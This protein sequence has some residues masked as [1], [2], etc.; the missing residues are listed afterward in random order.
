MNAW[1]PLDDVGP[2]NIGL[3]IKPRSHLDWQVCLSLSVSLCVSLC[4]PLSLNLSVMQLLP[5]ERYTDQPRWGH[6][7][8]GA[9]ESF[10]RLRIPAASIDFSDVSRL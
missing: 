8:D 5:H 2:D 9:F 3:A 6:M 7:K 4:V 1:L 10:D